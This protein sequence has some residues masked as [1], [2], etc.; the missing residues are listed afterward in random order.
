MTNQVLNRIRTV[1]CGRYCFIPTRLQIRRVL[2]VLHMI[3]VLFLFVCCV[4]VGSVSVGVGACLCAPCFRAR[5]SASVCLRISVFD[6]QAPNRGAIDGW[7]MDG[8]GIDLLRILRCCCCCCRTSSVSHARRMY[9][10]YMTFAILIL[11]RCIGVGERM[12][13]GGDDKIILRD[14][15]S[16]S[17]SGD[18]H[19]APAVF[20]LFNPHR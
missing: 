18:S 13:R 3:V 5:A 7:N 1:W 4:L 10:V 2:Y 6:F 11:G 14:L 9:C 12:D 17:S 16:N 15:I 19:F 20:L 8:C